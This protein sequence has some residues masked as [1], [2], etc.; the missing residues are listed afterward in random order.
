MKRDEAAGA[1]VNQGA[2]AAEAAVIQRAEAAGQ[3]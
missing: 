2:E 1:T 3:L